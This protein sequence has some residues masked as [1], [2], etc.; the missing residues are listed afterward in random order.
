MGRLKEEYFSHEEIETWSEVQTA[1]LLGLPERAQLA[2][3]T[4]EPIAALPPGTA[5]STVASISADGGINV[6]LRQLNLG[7]DNDSCRAYLE[8]IAPALV[9]G[10]RLLIGHSTGQH[11][12][13]RQVLPEWIALS[14]RRKVPQPIGRDEDPPTLIP[15]PPVTWPWNIKQALACIAANGGGALTLTAK[16]LRR[17]A[18]LVRSISQLQDETIAAGYVM[19]DDR[20]VLAGQINCR[21]ML[22]DP[23]MLG[24]EV[25]ISG[26]EVDDSLRHLVAIALFGTLCGSSSNEDRDD[27]D[28]R[29]IAGSRHA[30]SQLLPSADDVSGL[31]GTKVRRSENPKNPWVLGTIGGGIPVCLGED[32]RAR[33]LYVIGAT[34]TGKSTL[35][36]SLLLQ[37]IRAGEGA[38]LLDP[39]GD[40]A[41]DVAAAIPPARA[42]DLIYADA[43]DV[44]GR[45]AVGLLPDCSDSADFE[46][47]ADM[48]VS[49]FKNDLYSEVKEAFG[50]MFE[51]YF[52]SALAL[53][54]AADPS[55]R[56]L[57]NFPRVF[58]DREFRSRLL[59]N[60]TNHDVVAFWR[61]TVLRVSGEA[62][63]TNITPYITGKL[64][65]FI[66][67]RHA[68]AMFPAAKRCLNFSE[69]MDSGKIL[70]LRCPKGAIGEGLTELAMSACLM[71]IRAAAMA[72]EAT[73]QRR[74]VRVYIDE[75]QV[76]RGS[77]LQTLLAEGRKFGVSLVLANQS[78]GQIGGTDNRSIGAATLANVGNIVSFRVGAV[79]AARLAPWL[80]VPERWRDLCWLPDFTMNARLLDNGRPSTFNGLRSPPVEQSIQSS[81]QNCKGQFLDHQNYYATDCR[82]GPVAEGGI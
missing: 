69:A 63:L 81:Q 10:V 8:M 26:N 64:T 3:A 6:V 55:E 37:D 24:I 73:R 82:P 36:R 33:H 48:L 66:T 29:L 21:A 42:G 53:L 27:A 61:K 28:L 20:H 41:Q 2:G 76:C 50:P 16:N 49:I 71:K 34:G 1:A 40:L 39:H 60:C 25:L 56:Y 5:I 54:L 22:D 67:T 77:S 52:R 38:I 14:E 47:A 46:I 58:E 11:P 79:D 51:S 78:L 4:L 15:K 30:P 62:E 43:A 7:S 23:A 32:D 80:D 59:D 19:P 70:V 65:R 35:M 57:A 12:V 31:V 75:F 45:F 68:R 9:P 74:P 72:R 18:K 13:Q 44:E 17:T